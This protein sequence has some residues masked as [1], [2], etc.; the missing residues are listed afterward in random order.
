MVSA[1]D[2]PRRRHHANAIVGSLSRFRISRSTAASRARSYASGGMRSRNDAS[3]S[4]ASRVSSA[5]AS[6]ASSDRRASDELCVERG[7]PVQQRLTC[8]RRGRP[9]SPPARRPA[10][11]RP[12]RSGRRT[13]PR[14]CRWLSRR[15]VA[16]RRAE[17]GRAAIRRTSS[18]CLGLGRRSVSAF[19]LRASARKPRARRHSSK[20]SRTSASQKS[21]GPAAGAVPCG[22]SA[23]NTDRCPETRS[24]AE[25]P[26]SAQPETRSKDGPVTRT[27]WPSFFWQR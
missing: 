25:C 13:R 21:I 15:S 20:T 23:R 26:A 6:A 3:S 16:E 5:T 18:P 7:Q 11:A 2:S 27:R 1:T 17:G 22:S 14:G 12:D 24:S 10:R 8:C 9:G 4:S 19:A